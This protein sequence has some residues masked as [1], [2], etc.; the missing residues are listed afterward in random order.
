MLK[1]MQIAIAVLIVF[2][3]AAVVKAVLLKR[4][5]DEHERQADQAR[6]ERAQGD[7]SDD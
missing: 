4:K 2:I 6:A 5:I 1:E 3:I 7:A